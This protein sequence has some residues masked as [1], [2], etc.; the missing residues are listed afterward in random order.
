MLNNPFIPS[1]IISDPNEFFGRRDELG[2]LER[3][4]NRYSVAI[5]GAI[6]IGKS[7]LLY[8]IRLLMEGWHSAHNSKTIISVGN[9]DVHHVD[10]AARLILEEFV[11]VDTKHNTVELTVPKVFKWTST[12]I[13]ENFKEGRHAAVL[14]RI[15]CSKQLKE[16]EFLII[17]IDEADK[18]P[19]PLARLIRSLCTYAQQEGIQNIR[20]LMAGVSPF[21]QK[22]ID[23]DP[24]IS[25]FFKPLTVKPFLEDVACQLLEAK[26]K[27]LIKDAKSKGLNLQVDDEV[28]TRIYQLSGGHP[29]LLQLL[30]YHIVEHED[31]D[32]D[33]IINLRDLMGSLRTICYEDR[34]YVYGPL[35][36]SLEVDGKLDL[37]KSL[38]SKSRGDLPTKISKED[39]LTILEPDTLK[40]FVEND[41]LEPQVDHYTLIDEFLRVRILM[42]EELEAAD[43]IERRLIESGSLSDSSEEWGESWD[44]YFERET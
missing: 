36:H 41:I 4:I 15:I 12:T 43:E 38:L 19:V 2:I 17:A 39:A 26:F 14:Q 13:S 40:W 20:F 29:H 3:T 27:Q 10:E 33:E 44:E 24:G 37:L 32:P 7:S 21:F 30:G 35:I 42:D 9:R 23:D 22:M 5:Q 31:H 28:V 11:T 18:C 8:H 16:I 34:A 6:G 1:E 25:R